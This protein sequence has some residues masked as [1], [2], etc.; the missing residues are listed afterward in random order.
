MY[1][2]D[3][4]EL[5]R[6]SRFFQDVRMQ[7]H[8]DVLRCLY[9]LRVVK[10]NDHTVCRCRQEVQ[11]YFVTTLHLMVFLRCRACVRHILMWDK[12]ILQ[13]TGL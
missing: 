11:F 12:S 13:D 5:S 8:T 1:G 4:R 7:G 3:F 9:L 10:D 6:K 2:L